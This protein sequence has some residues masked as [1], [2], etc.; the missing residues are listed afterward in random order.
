MGMN[1]S[2]NRL[3]GVTPGG[4]A[5]LGGVCV[6]WVIYKVNG[7]IQPNDDDKICDEL[8][9]L[10]AL[11][12]PFVVTFKK[13]LKKQATAVPPTQITSSTTTITTATTTTITSTIE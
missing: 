1:F 4:Q 13:Q 7:N 2:G 12:T 3:V 8:E 11:Q 9:A 10:R 5:D 6:G